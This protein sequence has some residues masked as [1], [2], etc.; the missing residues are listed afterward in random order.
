MEKKKAKSN[1]EKKSKGKVKS[2]DVL[3]YKGED[4]PFCV[5]PAHKHNVTML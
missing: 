4:V 2:A 5:A 3:I 1:Q